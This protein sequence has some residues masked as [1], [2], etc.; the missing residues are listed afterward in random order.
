MA[1]Q[2]IRNNNMSIRKAATKHGIPYRT[3]RH[4]FKGMHTKKFGGQGR[5]SQEC[6]QQLVA[7][8]NTLTQWKVPLNGF[9]IRLLVKS[10]LDSRDA[11]DARFTNNMPGVDWLNGFA[12]RHDLTQ[13]M[14]TNVKASRAEI[15]SEMISEYID[16]LSE[17]SNLFNYDETNVTDDPGAKKVFVRRGLCRIEKKM[18]HSKQTISIMFC[19]NAM[20]EFLPPLVVY[21]AKNLHS[22]CTENGPMGALND[23]TSSGWFDSRTFETWF[24][25]L[26]LPSISGRSGPVAVIGDN[27]PSHF[28]LKVVEESAKHNVRFITMPPNATHL[29]QPLDVAVFSP[30]KRIWR[31]ILEQWRKE[32]R[33]KGSIA[34]SHFPSL[35]KKL[36]DGLARRNMI[37]GFRATGLYPLDRQQVL[38]RIP[39]ANNQDLDAV[40]G[41]ETSNCLNA[42]V[43]DLL[44]GRCGLNATSN[45]TARSTLKRGKKIVPGR[46]L[47]TAS[48]T[49]SQPSSSSSH[50]GISTGDIT[51]FSS[52]PTDD[53]WICSECGEPWQ[54]NSDDRWILC[55]SCD[56]QY[57]LQCSGVACRK[58]EYYSIDVEGMS[59][60]CK[61]CT[62]TR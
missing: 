5:L 22:S 42:S 36:C 62:D 25:N 55:D 14:A 51:I 53:E 1:L 2:E 30:A 12:K 7:S 21:R 10:Y 26:F 48:L 19:G 38:K 44:Q 23:A 32:S 17:P 46:P 58:K 16:N 47:T 56:K 27:L 20:G 15:S 24:I 4:K 40:G 54:E 49:T 9:D 43:M 52:I 6:E 57:H 33:V 59:F 3:L 39:N 31:R 8:I 61:D 60:Y 41:P 18:E 35:L 37:S 50:Q 13:R 28:S 11:D 45:E 29:C 34:K